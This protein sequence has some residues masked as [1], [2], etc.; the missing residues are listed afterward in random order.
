MAGVG[1]AHHILRVELLLC[2]LGHG[3]GAVLLGTTRREGS[4]TDHEEM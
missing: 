4:E 2:E 1:G 3:E